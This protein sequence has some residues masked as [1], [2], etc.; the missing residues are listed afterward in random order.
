[1]LYFLNMHVLITSDGDL[2]ETVLYIYGSKG[3]RIFAMFVIVSLAC[4]LR[5]KR[6]RGKRLHVPWYRIFYSFV[7][8]GGGLKSWL[9]LPLVF[10]LVSCTA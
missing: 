7:G 5:T 6:N 10:P 8:V 9:F 4:N 1:L 2:S 3:I